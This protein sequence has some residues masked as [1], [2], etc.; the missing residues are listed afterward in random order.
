MAKSKATKKF[1]QRHLQDSLKRRKNFKS[2]QNLHTKRKARSDPYHDKP[3]E[4]KDGEDE[5]TSAGAKF[6][7][8]TVDDFFE[9]GFE[10]PEA[11]R[12]KRKR[13]GAIEKPTIKR[14]KVEQDSED[15]EPVA[16]DSSDE[17]DAAG[18][19]IEDQED[20]SEAD[21]GDDEETH[22][23]DLDQL[24][25]NDPEFYKYLQDNDAELLDFEQ[26]NFDEIDQLSDDGKSKKKK[27]MM[28]KDL[29]SD[30][31]SGTMNLATIDRWER[32]MTQLKSLRSTR[33]MILAF[34]SAVHMNNTKKKDYKYT[35]TNSDGW[36]IPCHAFLGFANDT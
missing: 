9:G 36:F 2:K 24:A 19:M 18:G 28:E 15:E 1:E 10:V 21:S 14:T 31:T 20:D 34:R 25:Q 7:D 29:D 35:I 11:P 32:A 27:T 22:K 16:E 13:G 26:G 3:E 6:A 17:A 5:S 33:E 12:K 23:H 4:R 30:D 8:M